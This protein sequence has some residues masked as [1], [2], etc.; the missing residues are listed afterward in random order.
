MAS[1]NCNLTA[2]RWNAEYR[3]GRYADE[4]P[5]PFVKTILAVLAQYPSC[6]QGTGLYIGCGNGRNY[7]P[8]AGAGL[9][10]IGLDLSAESLQQLAARHPASAEQLVC[11]DL[12]DYAPETLFSYLVAIQV[13]QHGTEADINTYFAKAASLLR[14]GG[15][16]F[17]RVNAASTQIYHDHRMIERNAFGGLTICYESGPKQDL[18]I[19]F[20][21]RNELTR[22][23][24][25]SFT[26]VIALQED[27][28]LRTA[29]KTGFWAQWEGGW[30]RRVDS[31][32][33]VDDPL[34]RAGKDS[35]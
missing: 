26:P 13:F 30:Q 29:P 35:T 16:F 4:P 25:K 5:V 33:S 15:L 14:P 34:R 27:I 7:L 12:R 22:L 21:S 9:D 10:L 8:L 20:Y 19:H 24:A 28:T 6:R 31:D 3:H 18:P 23:T 32:E 1:L 2:Q 17:L 11:S